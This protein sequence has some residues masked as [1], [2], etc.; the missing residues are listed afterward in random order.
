MSTPEEFM[1][2][3]LELAYSHTQQ[4]GRPFAAVLVK[5]GRVVATGVNQ[6]L[7]THDPTAHAEM[8]AIRTAA[9][10]QQ[11]PR[12]DGHITYASG[13]PCPMCLAAMYLTGVSTAYYAY[14]NTEAEAYGL[15]TAHLYAELA[16]PFSAQAL[17]LIHLPLRPS[18]GDLYPL[19]QA[20]QLQP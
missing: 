10:A 20:Q 6:M 18:L 16:K 11:A 12:L 4:G 17:P 5:A 8:E 9:R 19:W 1:R 7:A 3:A 14:S 15:S 13:H 2:M